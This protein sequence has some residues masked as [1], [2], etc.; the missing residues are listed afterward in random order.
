MFSPTF[1]HDVV[2]WCRFRVG[3]ALISVV[4]VW[5]GWWRNGELSCRWRNGLGSVGLLSLPRKMS[6]KT[7]SFSPAAMTFFFLN[8]FLERRSGCESCIS[9]CR[10]PTENHM[11]SVISVGTMSVLVSVCV[12]VV[13][14][15]TLRCPVVGIQMFTFRHPGVGLDFSLVGVQKL[16]SNFHCQVSKE[17]GFDCSFLG[18]RLFG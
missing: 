7:H 3:C 1:E 4:R 2:F 16:E 9:L 11:I 18:V 8:I 14:T 5:L 17:V 12:C 6:N 15:S 13:L 10:N